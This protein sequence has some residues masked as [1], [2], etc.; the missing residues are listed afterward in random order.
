VCNPH[1][2]KQELNYPRLEGEGF[3]KQSTELDLKSPS[4]CGE[5]GGSGWGRT[6]KPLSPL[7][8]P[9]PLKGEGGSGSWTLSQIF[10]SPQGEGFPPSPRQELTAGPVETFPSG[11]VQGHVLVED[12]SG[13]GVFNPSLQVIS[14]G[15]RDPGFH[16]IAFLRLSFEKDAPV[17]LRGLGFKSTL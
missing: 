7:S 12:G 15:L 9:S 3:P 13:I 14:E 10:A 16:K 5:G 11:T 17:D 8:Q 4:P 6:T 1:L 2:I